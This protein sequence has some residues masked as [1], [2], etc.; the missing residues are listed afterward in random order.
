MVG[1]ARE[2]LADPTTGE[3]RIG[4]LETLAAGVPSPIIDVY[5][6]LPKFVEGDLTATEQGL[7][8]SVGSTP[9]GLRSRSRTPTV[10][11]RSA[12]ASDTTG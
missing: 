4:C 11:S 9:P 7:A 1:R 2:F 12:I 6:P 8:V 3:V 10:F 5:D